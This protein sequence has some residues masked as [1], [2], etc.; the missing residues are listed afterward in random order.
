MVPEQ[1]GGAPQHGEESHD[2]R[3]LAA[4]VVVE[5]EAPAGTKMSSTLHLLNDADGRAGAAAHDD[6]ST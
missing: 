3:Q 2:G 4:V 6:S 1:E 5:E